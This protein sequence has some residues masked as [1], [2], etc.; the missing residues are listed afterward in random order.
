LV[1]TDGERGKGAV[2]AAGRIRHCRGGLVPDSR[3]EGV[4]RLEDATAFIRT[5]P[6]NEAQPMLN[7]CIGLVLSIDIQPPSGAE[8]DA[9]RV[10]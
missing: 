4:G 8:L 1:G 10:V 2:A 3:H 7:E 5:N 9:G 6:L